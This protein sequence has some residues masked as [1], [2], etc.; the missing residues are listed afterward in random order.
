MSW[1]QRIKAGGQVRAQYAHIIDMV[2][3]VLDLLGIDPPAA[4]RGVTQSPLHGVSFA[5]TLGEFGVVL[6]VGGNLAG[7]TRTVSISI[8]DDVQALNYSAAM[9]TSLLLLGIS[10]LVLAATYGL[11]RRVWA[12][13]PPY[14]R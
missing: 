7:I 8:Y 3:T 5:H 4:I 10:F 1:P 11:R 14:G 6:M 13:W 2:P 12:V 9:H